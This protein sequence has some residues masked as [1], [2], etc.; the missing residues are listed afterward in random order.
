MRE[1]IGMLVDAVKR[2]TVYR[3]A[4]IVLVVIVTPVAIVLA[5]RI[6]DPGP[7]AS[8]EVDPTVETS[9]ASP[10]SATPTPQPRGPRQAP[11]E[12]QLRTRSSA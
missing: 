7:L 6:T 3:V 4:L 2:Q 10:P 1:Q 12:W 9:Y 8:T 5:S 11:S